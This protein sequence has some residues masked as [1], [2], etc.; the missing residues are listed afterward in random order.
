MR[1]FYRLVP[2]L[3]VF[4]LISACGQNTPQ[5]LPTLEAS[6]T[7][8]PATT[9]PL[10][11]QVDN[12]PILPTTDPNSRPGTVRII[13][14]AGVTATINV[15]A[16]FLTIATNLDF[17]Q[18]TE[19]TPLD[20]GEYN[21]EIMPSGSR[22]GD[23]AL[24]ETTYILKS[25][26][27][28][29]LVLAKQDGQF[30]L[31][32][33]PETVVPLNPGE[34]AITVI[35]AISGASSVS[36]QQNGADLTSALTF[37]QNATSGILP[38]GAT[39]LTIE[40]G[41]ATPYEIELQ[42]QQAY[43][44]VLTGQSDNVL[45]ASYSTQA[46]GRATVRA[47]NALESN[48][49]VDIYLDDTLF[50]AT[51]EY[52]R[53]TERQ[54]IISGDYDV[55]VYPTGADRTAVEPLVS[56]N[57]ALEA[58]Q[59]NALLFIGTPSNTL[60]VPFN[61]D[62]SAMPPGKAR[63]AFLNTLESVSTLR[64]ETSGG[65]LSDVE[66]TSFG[67]A[68]GQTLL[69]AS[70]YIFFLTRAGAPEESRT[71][72]TVQNVQLEQGN[73]Y[74]YLVTGQQDNQPVI[75]SEDIGFDEA[76]ANVSPDEINGDSTDNP[77][78]LR[79][80]NAIADQ[81]PID[82]SINSHPIATSI[83]YGQGSELIAIEQSSA[84]IEALVTGSGDFLQSSE[85]SLESG[86]RYTVIAYGADRSNVRMMVVPD[87]E[88]IFDGSSPHLR[89]INLSINTDTS[90]G[91][92]FSEQDPTPESGIPAAPNEDIR[93]S[94]PG[95]VQRLVEDIPGGGRSTTV[96]MP[97]GIYDLEI[98]DSNTDQ[99]ATTF[100]NIQLNSGAHSDVIVYEENESTR[101]LGFVVEYPTDS[102][103]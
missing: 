43:T 8:I 23:P 65:P 75:L 68:P 62:L 66:D 27:A 97:T 79:F 57:L 37:G 6:P 46:P 7:A 17:T 78:Q 47:V 94:I 89:L 32:S 88:L 15:S 31:L 80:I 19:P 53:P 16:G 2:L 86:N 41:T 24:F 5:V 63:I 33:F 83:A 67:E 38:S 36:L 72:E 51:L 73:Y 74:L 30:R 103:N 76:L 98:L 14:A 55:S 11:D 87:N 10:S 29:I 59:N 90:L 71:V 25:G 45:V 99:L 85:N 61:E 9:T 91:L 69:D 96:L 20:A 82:F 77:I 28:D 95:G 52:A 64:V 92:G 21:I 102:S 26:A 42:E 3:L 39:S 18:A 58:G 1:F 40:T 34:S 54:N 35:N 44:L 93:H 22:P 50:A 13:H 56:Q 48:T 101:I 100:S 12:A 70:S 49:T 60:V 81:T 84:T 4:I